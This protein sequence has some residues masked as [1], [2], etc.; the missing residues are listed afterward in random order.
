MTITLFAPDHPL[1]SEYLA[2][3]ERATMRRWGVTEDNQPLPDTSYLGACQLRSWSS[4]RRCHL[5]LRSL[6]LCALCVVIFAFAAAIF[7]KPV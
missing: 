4:L 5:P 3:L 1:W 2:H 6:L 7:V